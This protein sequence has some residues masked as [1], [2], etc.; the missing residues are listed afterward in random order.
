MEF[1]F[2]KSVLGYTKSP[3]GIIGLFI[4]LVYGI[5][6]IAFSQGNQ[7]SGGDITPLIYFLAL[8][9]VL[10]FVGFVWLVAKHHTKLYGPAD[11]QNEELFLKSNFENFESIASLVA[12]DV[13]H[14]GSDGVL[15][16]EKLNNLLELVARNDGSNRRKDKGWRTRVLWVDDRPENNVFERKAFEAQGVEFTIALS[17]KSALEQLESTKFGAVISDM[18]RKEGP[19]EGYVLLSAMQER[20]INTPF[21][22]YAG[23][24][25]PEHKKMAREQ[26]AIGSTN[27]PDELF[28]LVMN[29]LAANR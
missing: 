25:S 23:S 11:F 5:A 12:A 17:T 16:E 26:G 8:F 27:R 4:V 9:P 14:G 15:T 13:K 10:V 19:K 28:T 18:G 3:L 6:A 22:I 21:V 20:K 24:N 1:N 29:A 2:P 7:S